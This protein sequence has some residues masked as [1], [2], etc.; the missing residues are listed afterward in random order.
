MTM[1]S[2]NCSRQASRITWPSVN[3]EAIS[4][5]RIS[6][7]KTG[8]PSFHTVLLYEDRRSGERAWNFYEKLTRKFEGDF[9]FSHLMWSFSMLSDSRT[10]ELAVRSAADAHLVILSF[11]GKTELPARIRDWIERWARLAKRDPALVSLTD[12][13]VGPN[14]TTQAYLREILELHGIDFFPHNTSVSRA[15]HLE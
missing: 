2:A 7:R 14:T 9:E 3:A 5:A 6:P 12:E 1:H 8:A 11:A 10:S 13:K 4:L 15:G